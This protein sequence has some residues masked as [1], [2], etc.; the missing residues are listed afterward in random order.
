MRSLA[1][2]LVVAKGRAA[3]KRGGAKLWG[4]L[5]FEPT[6][7]AQRIP[8]MLKGNGSILSHGTSHAKQLS[9]HRFLFL[10]LGEERRKK[11]D[12]L[13]SNYFIEFVNDAP[14]LFSFVMQV[15]RSVLTI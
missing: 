14:M 7:H 8:F 12:C 1:D 4:W 10:V 6:R 3:L 2:G 13:A 9:P 15:E 11:M 5:E